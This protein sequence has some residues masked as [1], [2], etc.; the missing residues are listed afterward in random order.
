MDITRQ[1]L[2]KVKDGESG[3]TLNYS[4][5]NT[6]HPYMLTNEYNREVEVQMSFADMKRLLEVLQTMIW[7]RE[8]NENE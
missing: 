7:E 5:E 1:V 3:F 4:S 6:A 2:T 8:G